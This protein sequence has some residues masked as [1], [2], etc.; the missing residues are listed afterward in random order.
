MEYRTVGKTGVKVSSLCF[1]TMSFGGN[2]DKETSKKMFQRTREVGINFY[3]CANAYSRGAAEEILGECIADCRDEIVLTTKVYN[4]M[5]D[6]INARG[7]SRRHI[8]LEVEN[9]LRRLKT[10]RID[11]YFV[12]KFDPETPIEETLRALDDLKSQ[13]K[14]LYPA[15]SNWAAWQMAKA[16]GISEKESLARF[17]LMQPM[18]NLAKRQAEVEILPFAESEQ[19][20]VITYSPLGGGLLSGKY[21]ANKKPSQGRL[22]EEQMYTKRYADEKNFEVAEKFTAYAKEKE[23][24]PATLAVAWAMAHPAVTAPIIGARNLE[25]LEPALAAL[26]LNMTKEWRDE[27]SSLSSAPPLATDRAEEV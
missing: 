22:V 26:K 4:P 10:D 8:M 21:G 3:D 1:G 5:S 20:G 18:Y 6:D 27:I 7:L 25:Q 9:S 23:V 24:H 12:H 13:G 2:A 19:V 11:F 15:V 17:E 16:L 14:I